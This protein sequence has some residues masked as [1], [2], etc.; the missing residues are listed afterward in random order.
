MDWMRPV[1]L[2][3]E[4]GTETALFAEPLNALASLAFLLAA[5][6]AWL[7]YRRL[8]A[9]QRSADH[10]LLMALCLLVGLGGLAFHLYANQWSE[11]ADMAPLHLFMLVF[12][13]FV[14]QRFLL[15]PPGWTALLALLFMALTAAA[16]TMV[17]PAFDVALQP[18]WAKGQATSCLN[19][20]GAFLPALAVLLLSAVL[21]RRR[22]HPAAAPLFYAALLFALALTFRAVDHLY[23][24]QLSLF[25]HRLGTHF[26]W[27]LLC[28]YALFRLLHLSMRHY[29]RFPALEIIP[30]KPTKRR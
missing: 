26:L 21:L 23:C 19:G 24:R 10:L 8:A 7:L 1:W 12:L 13:A 2:Y 30:P 18:A 29:T 28:A 5:L 20:V 27:R 11:L 9:L 3:C 6:A 15:V 16:A 22:G 14:A 25:G 4:R 17:C